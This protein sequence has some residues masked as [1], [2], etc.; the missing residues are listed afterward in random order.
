MNKIFLFKNFFLLYI[1]VKAS[2]QNSFEVIE[3]NNSTNSDYV[4]FSIHIDF[5]ALNDTPLE[6]EYNNE[7][8]KYILI[9]KKIIESFLSTNIR[10]NISSLNLGK[11]CNNAELDNMKT[12]GF[13]T[14]LIIIPIFD[15]YNDIIEKVIDLTDYYICSTLSSDKRP[16][17]ATLYL[18]KL[19][20]HNT[21]EI[22]LTEILHDLFHILGFREDIRK[23]R[24][25]NKNCLGEKEP[26]IEFKKVYKKYNKYYSKKV[27]LFEMHDKY[28]HWAQS[29][30]YDIMSFEFYRTMNFNEYTLRYLNN[31]KWYR[32]NMNIC[33][34]S[35][36]GECSFGVFPYEIYINSK[37]YQLYCY[38]N[39]VFNHKCYINK[40]TYFPYQKKYKSNEFNSDNSYFG[41][42]CRNYDI[43]YDYNENIL[44]KNTLIK[45]NFS[46]QELILMSP[47]I[48]NY[49]KCHLKTIFFYN[50]E[51]NNFNEGVEQNYDLEK[52]RIT[53]LNKVVYGSF[54]SINP[55]HSITFKKVL[56]Y[57]NIPIINSEYSPNILWSFLEGDNKYELLSHLNKYSIIRNSHFGYDLGNKKIAYEYYI[58]YKRKFPNDFDYM[59]ET[60]LPNQK[61]LIK[62]KFIDYAFIKDDLWLCKKID[63]SLG[64]GIS[65]IKDYNDFTKCN[66]LITRYIHNPH[67]INNY[68]YHIRIYN[69]ISSF[70]PLKIYIYKE[71]QIMRASHEY[72]I[73]LN[74]T[75]DQQAFITNAHINYGKEGYKED[76]PLEEFKL[77][78][79]KE[80]GNWT[81]IWEQMKDICI[82]TIITIYDKEYNMI[83]NIAKT[84]S[85]S[86]FYLGMDFMID[87]NYKVWLL[88]GNKSP[89]MEEYDKVNRKN[90]IGL[91]TDIFNILGV[92]PYDHSNNL[93]LEN[94][95]CHFKNKEEEMI[96]DAF[97]EFNRPRGNLELIFPIKDTLSYYK[98]FFIKDYEENVRLWNLL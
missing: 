3:I 69:F 25:I 51:D 76:I 33:G 85:K 9:A 28:F 55:K 41:K 22:I 81:Y 61:D 96:N 7:I 37:N 43:K 73:D 8:K 46:E 59:P 27:F 75:E 90:K 24:K 40:N 93:P 32:V 16:L 34:C 6:I 56:K 68:K 18:S 52:L 14:N 13:N 70:I 26:N 42:F 84:D 4:P 79:I 77:I 47:K 86:L 19:L 15:L 21:G 92:I 53:D 67:L 2:S 63:G 39:D 89:F 29:I 30:K 23:N 36:K 88:E 80:G 58:D 82:K 38:R 54:S 12:C 74:S 5:Q 20:F 44:Y 62:N 45:K 94:N 1:I 64:D 95:N 78:I 49:C 57:N 31:L 97:C 11:I 83:K 71:G 72:K 35:L 10:Y 91:S 50:E 66:Q 60:Y 98:K 65:F 87:E 17:I 48:N